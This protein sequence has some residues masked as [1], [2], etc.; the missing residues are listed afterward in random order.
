M[1][2]DTHMIDLTCTLV[3]HAPGPINAKTQK[4][5]INT[6]LLEDDDEVVVAKDENYAMV[7][8]GVIY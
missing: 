4:D 6:V 2:E 1:V 5:S 8:N 7:S 3:S